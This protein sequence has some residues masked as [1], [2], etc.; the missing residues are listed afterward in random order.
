MIHDVKITI[1]CFK[2]RNLCFYGGEF[3]PTID[4]AVLVFSCFGV[5]LLLGAKPSLPK[6]VFF[7]F[8]A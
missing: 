4:F 1:N 5:L 6:I 3:G 7:D 8:A 2:L